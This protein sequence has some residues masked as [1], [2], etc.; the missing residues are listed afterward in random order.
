[1]AE[2]ALAFCDASLETASAA[3]EGIAADFVEGV[4]KRRGERGRDGCSCYGE[5]D[6]SWF[7]ARH[8]SVSQA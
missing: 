8:D 2:I 3:V 4:A 6:V 7:L 5:A 1:M